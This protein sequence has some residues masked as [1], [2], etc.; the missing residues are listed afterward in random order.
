[1]RAILSALATAALCV[2]VAGAEQRV[3]VRMTWGEEAPRA[4]RYY[5]KL[6]PETPGLQVTTAGGI[7]LESGEQNRDGVWQTQAGAGDVDGIDFTLTAPDAQDATLQNMEVIWADLIANSDADTARRLGQD[8]AIHPQSPRLT[9]QMDQAGTRGFTVTLDQ[10]RTAKALWIPSLHVYLAMGDD[11][12]SFAAHKQQLAPWAGKRIL[13]QVAREPEA[14]YKE[15][16]NR[17][18]DMGDPTYVNPRPRGPGHIVCLTWD[19]AIPK[20]GIDRGAGV[21]NDYGNPDHFR[22]WFN[23]GDIAQGI[24]H[25]WKGQHLHDGLPV[26]TTNF[27]K[28]GVRYEVEQFAYPLDGPP[29]QR[30]G[31]IDML[32]MQ[33]VRVTNLEARARRIPV[34][35]SHLRELPSDI[36]AK[37]YADRRGD[38]VLFRDRA[39]NRVLFAVSGFSGDLDW[40][41]VHD[42]ESKRQMKRVDGTVFVD[43]PAHGTSEVVVKLA[44]PMVSAEDAAKLQAID[45]QKAR[46]QTLDFWSNYVARGAHF[47]VP[48][49]AVNDLFRASLWHALRLPRRHG[50]SGPDVKIDL[51]YSNFAYSQTGTP[52][53]INQSVYVD[54]MLYDLRGYHSISDEELLAQF[55]N[56]QEA[57]GHINGVSNW[58]AYTPGMLYAVAQNYLLS[59]DRAALDRLMPYSLK[60]LDYCM[61]QI[62]EANLQS[63][64]NRGL[65]T[66]PLN[67]LTGT[68]VWAFNQAYMYAGLDLFGRVLE[69]VGNPRGAECRNAASQLR[70]AA[71]RGFRAASMRS[72]LV[73]LRDHTWEPYVPSEA[74]AYRRMLDEWYPADVDTG[75]VHM[76]RLK[77]IKADGQLAGWLLN[78]HE[79]NLY[80]K[81][82][83]IAN[84]PVYNQQATAY[85]LRDDPKAVIRAFYSYMASGFSHS[86]FEPVEHRWTH[87]QYFGP[88]ST[89]G[90]WFELYRNMLIHERDDGAL[91]LGMATP[92][93][94]LADGRKIDVERAPTYYGDL[95]MTIVSHAATGHIDASVT[96]PIN[97]RLRELLVRLRHPQDKTIRGVLVNGKN[98]TDFD[99]RKEW[100]RIA[101]PGEAHYEIRASY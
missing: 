44:S 56:N 76:I 84:E 41:G 62:H 70:D 89:D 21:W 69:E 13:D 6:T 66:A 29:K 39:Y 10:L 42:E 101:N 15:Y 60:A 26:I 27:E 3:R 43:L 35:F 63:G 88:P 96:M 94:W 32:L 22:F 78:D 31:D 38:T 50:G 99:T 95:S 28:D 12:L 19:S 87:G 85:L 16:T 11:P 67:D 23:F 59:H 45:Y 8:A 97:G 61:R 64:D 37:I 53:P 25:T 77:A 79:D 72:P 68:G 81:G 20:F 58:G 46:R 98:W 9:V 36:D 17:W 55:H 93:A 57:D 51:P 80:L 47:D 34:T 91:I 54:Y 48:E 18:E 82:W 24:I 7:S 75:A 74:N 4:D 1:M 65:V 14:T 2:S 83:G 90:A 40:N 86:V 52:W 73:E 30:R 33:Q 100:V 49:K 92:R 71:A 5:V